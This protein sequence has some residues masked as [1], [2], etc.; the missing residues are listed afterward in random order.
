[1]R[2]FERLHTKKFDGCTIELIESSDSVIHEV[3]VRKQDYRRGTFVAILPFENATKAES[4]FH[5]IDT[6]KIVDAI[7]RQCGERIDCYC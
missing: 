1:M 5:R 2:T 3:Y 7:M 4:E 6:R